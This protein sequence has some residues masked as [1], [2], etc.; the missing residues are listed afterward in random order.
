MRLS[1][2]VGSLDSD[3]VGKL[4][5][6]LPWLALQTDAG[7]GAM[8]GMVFPPQR[9]KRKKASRFEAEQRSAFCGFAARSATPFP[10]ANQPAAVTAHIPK[11]GGGAPPSESDSASCPSNAMPNRTGRPSPR[12]GRHTR[13]PPAGQGRALAHTARRAH[14]L[15]LELE[16]RKTAAGHVGRHPRPTLPVG[17][18]WA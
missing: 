18:C 16:G 3:R 14:M 6:L 12:T 4:A 2:P 13:Q 8:P 11:G 17:P 15:P 1:T 7:K 9:T 10:R 5:A